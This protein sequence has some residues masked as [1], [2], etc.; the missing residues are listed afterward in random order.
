MAK[1]DVALLRQTNFHTI[2]EWV[3]GEYCISTEKSKIDLDYVHHFLSRSYWAE[4]IPV[5]V[6]RRSV[7]GSL[8]FGVYHQEK[9]VGFARV[10]TDEATFAYLADVFID[11]GYRGRGLGKWLMEVIMQYPGLQGLRRFMLGTRDAHG[12]YRQFGFDAIT[13]PDRLMQI[14]RPNAYKQKAG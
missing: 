11:E 13:H 2:M 7:A 5:D 3:K 1:L 10:I 9:Q 6:V 12:L 14:V 4:D 8:S